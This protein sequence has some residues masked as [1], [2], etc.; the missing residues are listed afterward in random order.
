MAI[1][2]PLPITITILYL[3]QSPLIREKGH[4]VQTTK[5]KIILCFV[6]VF[7]DVNNI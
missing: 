3:V 7:R 1:G 6:I 5:L 2:T 4:D